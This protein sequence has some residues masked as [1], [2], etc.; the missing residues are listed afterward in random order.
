M[1]TIW[2][3]LIPR[4]YIIFFPSRIS[5]WDLFE[6]STCAAN[7]LRK[8]PSMRP[9]DF[10]LRLSLSHSL[11]ILAIWNST[12]AEP[13]STD[14]FDEDSSSLESNLDDWFY[15]PE[16]S[17]SFLPDRVSDP[18]LMASRLS[19]STGSD[20]MDSSIWDSPDSSSLQ[21]PC[22][23]QSQDLFGDDDGMLQARDGDGATCANPESDPTINQDTDFSSYLD[24][25]QIPQIPK[26]F[27]PAD[28]SKPKKYVIPP[29][30]AGSFITEYE[31]CFLPYSIRCC[32][33]G[34]FSWGENSMWG[35]TLK[36][37]DHCS[38]G[39]YCT[40]LYMS[41]ISNLLCVKKIRSGD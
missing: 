6:L 28:L 12:R 32:C 33:G 21:S 18:S 41:S 29:D 8:I 16:Q 26:I 22:Q 36:Q 24:Q 20:A 40:I 37:I 13:Q 31:T 2:V 1:S 35:L 27:V 4:L 17:D 30:P 14:L 34:T 3:L 38:V 10:F 15:E 5:N 9:N 19:E 23:M 11:A 7:T 25:Q 39:T